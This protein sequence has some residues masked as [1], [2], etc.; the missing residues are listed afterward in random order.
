MIKCLKCGECIATDISECPACGAIINRVKFNFITYIGSE[1]SLFGYQ[2]SYKL[3]LLKYIL[4]E[5]LSTGQARVTVVIQNI[6]QFYITRHEEGLLTDLD[7]DDRIKNI[8]NSSDHDV[9]AVMKAQPFKVINEKGFLFLNRTPSNELIF[10]L[11]EDISKS[12][13]NDELKNLLVIVEKKLALYYQ[14]IDSQHGVAQEVDENDKNTDNEIPTLHD[15][16]QHTDTFSCPIFSVDVLEIPS[17]S[18]RAK[19]C[20]KRSNLNTIQEVVEFLKENELSDI[21]NLGKSTQS[22]ILDI[23]SNPNGHAIQTC[24]TNDLF[25]DDDIFTMNVQ[26]VPTLSIRAKN[27]LISAGLNTLQEVSFFLHNDDLTS[28]PNLGLGT[29]VEILGVLSHLTQVD[30]E[31]VDYANMPSTAELLVIDASN[32]SLNIMALNALGVST[33][34]INK[35]SEAGYL[36]IGS[37]DGIG[38]NTIARIVG[39]NKIDA[40]FTE[41]LKFSVPITEVAN[42][43]LESLKTQRNFEIY[44]QIA[45]G[46]NLQQTGKII[47]MTRSR[48]Q[49][50]ER[51]VFFLLEHFSFSIFHKL[52]KKSDVPYVTLQQV[53]DVF[54]DDDFDKVLVYTLKNCEDIEYL[55][56]A[57]IFVPKNDSTRSIY[58]DL[59]NLAK[60]FVGE[61]LDFFE[62]LDALEELLSESPFSYITSDLFIDLLISMKAKFYGSF[63]C[64]GRISYGLLCAKIVSEKFKDGINITSAGE[65]ALLR[66]YVTEQY[67]DLG[68]PDND[69]AL[70]ARISEFLV[71]SGRS[72]Y[73]AAENISINFDILNEI[74]EYIDEL[75]YSNVHYLELYNEFEGI[76]QMTTNIDNYQFL[77]GVLMHY[78]PNEYNYSRDYLTKNT[79]KN[80]VSLSERISQIL[81]SHGQAMHKNDLNSKLGGYSDIMIFGAISSSDAVFQWEFNYYNCIDNIKITDAELDVFRSVITTL[82][83]INNGYCSDALLFDELNHS[84]PEFMRKNNIKNSSNIFYVASCL[85]KSNFSFSRPHIC[86]NDFV[87]NPTTK[88]IALELLGN[89]DVIKYSDFVF[90]G[91]KF[92]WSN[93]TMGIVFTDIERSYRRISQNEY[94]KNEL[95]YVSATDLETIQASIQCSLSETGKLSLLNFDDYESFPNLTYKWNNF[96]LSTVV[97]VYKLGFKIIQPKTKDRRYQK[98]IIVHEDRVENSLAE[99]VVEELLYHEILSLPENQFLSFLTVNEFTHKVI[100]KELYESEIIRFSEG[101]FSI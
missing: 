46:L 65:I 27:C 52:L 5:Y 74:K 6:K 3:V 66:S 32:A 19:N 76:L 86:A 11:H 55:D 89:T 71:L 75:N 77:H 82:V 1:D 87:E 22:E 48:V 91:N 38:Q 33:S 18:V 23:I 31:S 94:I 100:P 72:K 36:T 10:A 12:F 17:L 78:F 2:K 25:C 8:Q 30:V 96:L 43:A 62:N 28:I 41:L 51:K 20:L 73:I 49:Q 35:L 4:E 44:L 58:A 14:K 68:L 80:E 60:D 83:E 88:H 29:Q 95:F 67:G 84:I 34:C 56:F 50:I 37:L 98:G 42:Y 24:K 39:K 81:T 47:G 9:F 93:V 61:G 92:R 85:F 54:D 21:R 79:L 40:V 15:D 13:S 69:R 16:R 101:V 64:F 53:L 70:C 26:E 57:E 99:L 59:V 7:A 45:S 90:I 63:V 97:E